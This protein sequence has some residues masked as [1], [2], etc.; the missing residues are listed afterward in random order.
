MHNY[1]TTVNST[2]VLSALGSK[3]RQTDAIDD[4]GYKEMSTVNQMAIDLR[5]LRKLREKEHELDL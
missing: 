1:T 4:K 2:G 3:R 5:I